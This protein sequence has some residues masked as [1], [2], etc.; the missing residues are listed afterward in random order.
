MGLDICMDQ[1]E[2][3]SRVDVM[4]TTAMMR[5]QRCNLIQ[6]VVSCDDDDDDVGV[7]FLF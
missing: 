5:L 2:G 3:E 7:D 6:R 4:K 1:L